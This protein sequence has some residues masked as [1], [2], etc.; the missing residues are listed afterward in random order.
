M[1]EEST[2]TPEPWRYDEGEPGI[3][4]SI[5]PNVLWLGE[6]AADDEA[7]ANTMRAIVCVNACAG[8]VADALAALPPGG[9]HQLLRDVEWQ[10]GGGPADYGFGV[11]PDCGERRPDEDDHPDNGG[12][13]GDCTIAALL[14][15]LTP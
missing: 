11:C 13:R 7:V 15:R 3:G 9:L 10:G 5:E 12:H 8:F 6:I 4:S 1:A 2:H 14:G